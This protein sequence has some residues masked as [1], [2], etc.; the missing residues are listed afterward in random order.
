MGAVFYRGI[1]PSDMGYADLRYY[2]DWHELISETEW[3]KAS[4]GLKNA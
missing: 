4:Q 2:H 1:N 3:N